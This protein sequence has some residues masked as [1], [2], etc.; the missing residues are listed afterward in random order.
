MLCEIWD[1]AV[2]SVVWSNES[3]SQP[4]MITVS[5]WKTA[6]LVTEEG[7]TITSDAQAK[8]KEEPQCI[9]LGGLMRAGYGSGALLFFHF[10]RPEDV[11]QSRRAPGDSG[12]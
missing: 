8:L 7:T 9:G 12:W 5:G 10:P 2:L 1:A 6:L 11:L 3:F 4:F